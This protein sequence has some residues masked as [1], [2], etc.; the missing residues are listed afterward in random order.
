MGSRRTRTSRAGSKALMGRSP[1]NTIRGT[2]FPSVIIRERGGQRG[3]GPATEEEPSLYKTGRDNQG[4]LDKDV[5]RHTGR[6]SLPRGAAAGQQEF[7][8]R[9]ARRRQRLAAAYQ[10]A[11]VDR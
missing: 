2:P 3:R 7:D 5:R 11:R 9:P 8:E 6:P 1:D 10:N 4:G